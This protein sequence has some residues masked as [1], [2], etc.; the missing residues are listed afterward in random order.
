MALFFLAGVLLGAGLVTGIRSGVFSMAGYSAMLLST[1]WFNLSTWSI[2]LSF[3][4]RSK[5]IEYYD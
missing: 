2:L 1:V 5:F 4:D 3:S